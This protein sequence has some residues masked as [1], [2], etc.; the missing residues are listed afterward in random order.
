MNI[1]LNNILKLYSDL[2]INPKECFCQ[3]RDFY[4][5]T[6]EEFLEKSKLSHK[7]YDSIISGKRI[8]RISCIKMC[9][10][11]HLP[12][13]VMKKVMSIFG[14]NLNENDLNDAEILLKY[15]KT[16]AK[17]PPLWWN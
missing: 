9:L 2:S 3:L 11:F 10:G 5:L 14:H 7:V 1:K 16:L 17:F 8:L 6:V 4:N 13:T 15:G 12:A